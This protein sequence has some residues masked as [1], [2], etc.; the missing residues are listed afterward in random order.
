MSWFNEK[1]GNLWAKLP[2]WMAGHMTVRATLRG[3]SDECIA[4]PWT[5]QP[6]EKANLIT[7]KVERYPYGVEY[8]RPV[9]DIDFDAE[10]LPSSTPGHW[11]LFLNKQM[12]KADYFDLLRALA[13]AGIIQH[14]FKDSA[15]DRG[16]SSVRLPWIKKNDWAANQ[17]DPEASVERLR[18]Q[19]K[20]AE[21][22]AARLRNE[23]DNALLEW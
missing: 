5:D 12:P 2:S 13:R 11:H 23:L 21:Q 14:G 22:E 3:E 1:V 15:I 4:E 8:H 7:S 10:L 18:E 19:V 6:I 17:G 20:K 9:L 16:A